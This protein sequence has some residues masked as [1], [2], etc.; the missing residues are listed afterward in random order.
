[1]DKRK[2]LLSAIL[3]GVVNGL[4]LFLLG[5]YTVSIYIA[6]SYVPCIIIGALSALFSTLCFWNL[7]KKANAKIGF[8]FLIS[9]VTYI[10][11]LCLIFVNYISVHIY[12]FPRRSLGN[13]D[14]II[15]ILVE[16]FY[17]VVCTVSRLVCCIA[18]K[19]FR[20]SRKQQ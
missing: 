9:M 19:V 1:M 11:V 6:E 8:F 3:D 4:L 2:L 5:E 14:G 12:I 15:L 18:I 13:G 17:T 7:Y 20:S 10:L 16:F